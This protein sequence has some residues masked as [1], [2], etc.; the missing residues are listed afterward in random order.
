MTDQPTGGILDGWDDELNDWT[1]ADRLTEA[2][3]E[4]IRIAANHCIRPRPDGFDP[5]A[6]P[7]DHTGRCDWFAA[8][9]PILAA[10]SDAHVRAQAARNAA[11][12]GA[13]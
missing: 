11:S 7:Y 5:C 4:A 2:E 13:A 8:A 3:L 12:D 9:Y 1:D 6:Q 10:D